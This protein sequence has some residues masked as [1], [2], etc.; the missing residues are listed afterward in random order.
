MSRFEADSPREGDRRF[1]DRIEALE[2]FAE[3]F[4]SQHPDEQRVLN[5]YGVGGIGKSR[6]QRELGKRF[7]SSGEAISVRLDLAHPAMR[8]QE[9]ALYYLRHCLASEHKLQL[10]RFDIAFAVHWQQ[11]HPELRLNASDLPLLEESEVLS[12]IMS[13]AGA[14]PVLG[15]AAGLLN[16]LKRTGHNAQR[17]RRIHA[18]KELQQLDKMEPMALL[19]ALTHF[20]AKDMRELCAEREQRFAIFIDAHEALAQ[21]IVTVAAYAD[22]DCWIR[23]LALQ[24]PGVLYVVCS[25]DAL[26][27]DREDPQW[28]KP[29]LQGC[30]L[31]DLSM[32]DRLDFLCSCGV[33]SPLCE[34]I[35]SASEGV[36]FYLNLA[37]DSW[38]ALIQSGVPTI[39]AIGASQSE[40]LM[41]FIGHIPRE[42]AEL[43]R[44]LSVARNWDRDLF[45]DLLRQFQIGYAISRFD[46]FA[47]Y[48]FVAET[49][50]QR[51]M[52]HTLMRDALLESL[53]PDLLAD[54]H[55]CIFSH[56]RDHMSKEGIRTAQ[57]FQFFREACYHAAHGGE[58]EPNWFIHEASFLMHRG[59]WAGM[60][61]V[62][63]ELDAFCTG[64]AEIESR[65][66]LL[67]LR[68]YLAA[69]ILRSQS[70]LREAR[71]AYEALDLTP[72]AEFA[73]GIRFQLANV[74]RECGEI[75][76]AGRIYEELWR[77]RSE[78]KD[79]ELVA[80]VGIQLADFHY[81]QGRFAGASLILQPNIDGGARKQVAEATRIMGHILRF[82]ERRAESL[83]LYEK[84]GAIFTALDDLYGQ[85]AIA[86]NLAEVLAPLDPERALAAA[87]RA[88]ELNDELGSHLEVGKAHAARAIARLTLGDATAAG[89][90]AE[91][92]LQIQ[93]GV[94][95]RM[96]QCQ[97]RLI[98]A[99]ALLESD[100]DAA[101]ELAQRVMDDLF[102]AQAYP[103]LI[104][105][106]ERLLERLKRSA[107]C[108]RE[109]VSWAGEA[110]EWLDGAETGHARLDDLTRTLI[111]R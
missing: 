44:V 108:P 76:A 83:A 22:R 100:V 111:R 23:D 3:I 97:A 101:A 88:I 29:R 36:P 99:F 2:V 46:E 109:A 103:T 57:R 15:I 91:R 80:L 107:D 14:V 4:A 104:L 63:D 39:E 26:R 28:S 65:T 1:T 42:E 17:W 49:T 86:T 66:T 87:Q 79:T 95:Y 62:L 38:E 67:A 37:V 8:R 77:G 18:D 16:I 92:A 50:G 31:G 56:Y 52:M 35:A 27:W 40:I 90:D 98:S 84:A 70:R 85:A 25:R 110:I 53:P 96:G 102:A 75:P 54:V 82:N 47:D 68:E 61:D 41:R 5:F 20:F 59:G 12:E 19:D 105:L 24:T 58:L 69:W 21:D 64:A 73:S 89:D 48:S 106:A 51:W 7:E 9:S 60:R 93:L 32:E 30:L 13:A 72:I 6:L 45:C 43:L 71:I 34:Q 55:R 10:P 94:G 81:V 11:A 33:E 78:E 74:L